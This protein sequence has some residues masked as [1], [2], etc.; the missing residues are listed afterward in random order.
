MPP[1]QTRRKRPT[2]QLV[3]VV[4]K[5]QARRQHYDFRLQMG[6]V[7]KSWALAKGPSLDPHCKRLAIA[8]E[9]H[10]LQY[11][12]FEGIIPEGY[13]A[14]TVMLWDQGTWVP[15]GDT[16]AGYDAGK[17]E[18]SLRGQKLNGRFVLVQMQGRFGNQ[19]LLI[20]QQDR[21]ARTGEIVDEQPS[22]VLTGRS[23]EQIAADHDRVWTGCGNA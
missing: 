16:H 23:L 5:H 20:K 11:A 21:W 6:G 13:G 3:F 9:D 7:L 22:S 8:V 4:H 19:W 14:G 2:S 15:E 17:L 12:D 1:E 18:F 10:P